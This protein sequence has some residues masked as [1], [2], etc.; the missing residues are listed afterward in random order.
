MKGDCKI[1]IFGDVCPTSDN[2][3]YFRDG[4]VKSLFGEVKS[5]IKSSDI[6]I[7]NLECA[8]T[9]TPLKA[10]KLGPVLHST[11]NT[12]KT[13]KDVGFDVLSL[14][15]N[16][17]LDCGIAGLGSTIDACCQNDILYVGVGN[18]LED[19]KK[20]LLIEKNGWR[21][22]ILA[23]AEQEFNTASELSAGA[24]YFDP[25]E[26]CD[27]IKEIR[28]DVDYMIFIYH[29]GI[30][31]YE[32]PSPLL[33]KKCRKFVD[34]GADIVLCQH[35][36]CIGTFEDYYGAKIVYGQGNSIF[37]YRKNNLQWNT[38]LVFT[39]NISEYK[40][41]I[42][43]NVVSTKSNGCIDIANEELKRKVLSELY[44]RS[45]KVSDKVFL[46]KSWL[47]FCNNIESLDIPL[48]LGWNRYFIFLNRKLKNKLIKL[49]YSRNKQNITLNLIRCESHYE[50][51]TSILNKN[52]Y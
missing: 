33:Q 44:Q 23:Y 9:N 16:H 4:D 27:R 38:G 18:N 21:I 45:E 11:I 47:E 6:T 19:S 8:L 22:A 5:M 25:Y 35:S 40:K 48:L 30:E 17:I 26:D 52:K 1:T 10:N 41:T 49:L 7:A 39:I 28:K 32:Y 20:P 3:I 43:I 50:V 12:A 36:H 15:N 29:G 42:D 24:S 31:Y 37:G 13:L 51:I 46:E 34:L 14:S 2:E